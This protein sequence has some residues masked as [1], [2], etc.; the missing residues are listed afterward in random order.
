MAPSVEGQKE[1]IQSALQLS[2]VEAESISYIETHG[3]GTQLGDSIEFT[4]LKQVFR[5]RQS[6]C[7]LGSVKNNIGHLDA[8]SGVAGFV[9]TVL[10]LKHRQIPPMI[11]FAR[12]NP[13][14]DMENSR[15]AINTTLREWQRGA[16]PLRAGI[17][18]FGVGG[19][20]A[21]LIV[22]EAPEASESVDTEQ[23]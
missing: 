11:N 14:L 23:Q 3:T 4:A 21:H 19:Q 7:V 17:S 8:A 6:E 2:D 13:A 16:Y 15:F 10:A 9:K 18:S 1:V 20:N 5:E 12:S 22:E